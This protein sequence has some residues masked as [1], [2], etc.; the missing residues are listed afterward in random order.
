MWYTRTYHRTS[1]T[2]TEKAVLISGRVDAQLRAQLMIHN[3]VVEGTSPNANPSVRRLVRVPVLS[4]RAR[5]GV[6]GGMQRLQAIRQHWSRS[7]W[8]SSSRTT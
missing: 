7:A 5:A 2:A 3:K 1:A 8:T 4:V 6:D